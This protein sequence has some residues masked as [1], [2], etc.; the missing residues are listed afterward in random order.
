M[1]SSI[2]SVPGMGRTN[3]IPL[4]QYDASRNSGGMI[5]CRSTPAG[6]PADAAAPTIAPAARTVTRRRAASRTSG[7]VHATTAV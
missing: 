5:Q 7:R 1:R 3:N 6:S 4:V 2:A